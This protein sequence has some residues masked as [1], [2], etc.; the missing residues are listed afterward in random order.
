MNSKLAS[1]SHCPWVFL[2]IRASKN[3]VK[4]LK[5]LKNAKYEM[6]QKLFIQVN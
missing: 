1:K 3:F 2:T 4:F 5:T 6:P